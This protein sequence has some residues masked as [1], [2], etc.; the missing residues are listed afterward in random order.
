MNV[1]LEK[2]L[3]GHERWE[4][5]PGMRGYDERSGLWVWVVGIR[6]N[7]YTGNTAFTVVRGGGPDI[8]RVSMTPP[9]EPDLDDPATVG[10]LI[11]MCCDA[12]LHVELSDDFSAC[13]IKQDGTTAS[14]GSLD[15]VGDAGYACAVALLGTWGE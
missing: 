9:D 7:V 13:V 3:A 2:R 15:A 8:S 5:M 10:C 6:R 11:K 4:W 14:C 12:G 1:E